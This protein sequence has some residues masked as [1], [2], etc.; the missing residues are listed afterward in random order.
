MATEYSPPYNTSVSHLTRDQV[1]LLHVAA[2]AWFQDKAFNDCFFSVDLDKETCG[3]YT[4]H[5]FTVYRG[6]IIGA[7]SIHGWFTTLDIGLS[8]RL[9]DLDSSGD[10]YS[11]SLEEHEDTADFELVASLGRNV[12]DLFYHQ[13]FRKRVYSYWRN[14]TIEQRIMQP[15]YRPF[16]S[17]PWFYEIEE[18]LAYMVMKGE[19]QMTDRRFFLCGQGV[20]ICNEMFPHKPDDE[21]APFM[22]DFCE[23]VEI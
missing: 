13:Y 12:I 20:N 15:Y 17:D 18:A 19:G 6:F 5:T 14:R 9:G 23:E 8:D 16:E 2:A 22:H 11:R 1:Q 4:P 10:W 21:L 7:S 3:L